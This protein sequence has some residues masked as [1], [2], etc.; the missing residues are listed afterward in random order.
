MATEQRELPMAMSHIDRVV[1]IEDHIFGRGFVALAINID[2]ASLKPDQI[3]ERGRIF[4]PGDSANKGPPAGRKPAG[5]NRK[6]FKSLI[7]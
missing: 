3:L 2:Q 6:A 5:S 4:E 7:A 1:E